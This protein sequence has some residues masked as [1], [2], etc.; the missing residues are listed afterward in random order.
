MVEVV[1]AVPARNEAE[2]LPRL[3]AALSLQRCAPAFTLVLFL[4]GCTD[5]SAAF[6]AD[7]AGR[8]PFPVVQVPSDGT[9]SA[10][11][12]LARGRACDLALDRIDDAVLLTTDADS[13]P[14][15]D[16]I[17]ST[18]AGLAVADIV[19]GQVWTEGAGASPTQLRLAAYLDRLHRF[20]RWVD[21][22]PWEDSST[23]HWTSA[24]SLAFR[25]G[26]YRRLGGFAPLAQGEDADLC[27]RAWRAGMTVRR[28]GRVRIA[29]SSRRGG[30][31]TQGFA[32][33]LA[34][35]DSAATGPSVSH[36]EDEAWR[37]HRHAE[38]RRGFGFGT[39]AALAASLGADRAA[40]DRIAAL[41]P[42][43]EA[44]TAHAVGNPPRG[45]RTVTL[46]H[47]EAI[48]ATLEA[49]FVAAVA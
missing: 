46:A 37:Y 3:C 9:A 41:V 19:A 39:T 14:E 33:L 13:A 21:P 23:H 18:C 5:G 2:H 40:L 35:L 44:F 12:G 38:A 47:A 22:V 6:V 48:L 42:N 8:L 4:D 11:V 45:M 15:P 10:N 29:T 27:D 32:T 24:A 31:V 7:M 17:A 20:R 43:A 30:R 34:S 36:P 26:V 1:V 25:P 49:G 28:D 16:W